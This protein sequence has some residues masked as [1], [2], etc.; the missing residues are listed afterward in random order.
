MENYI[1]ELEEMVNGQRDSE[2]RELGEGWN[3]Q[4]HK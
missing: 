1:G 3:V 2:E 4:E